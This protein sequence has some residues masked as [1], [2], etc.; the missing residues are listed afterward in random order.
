MVVIVKDLFSKKEKTYNLNK[1]VD[2]KVLLELYPGSLNSV[3]G[4]MTVNEAA[5]QIAKYIDSSSRVIS[6]TAD[7]INKA[8]PEAEHQK[9]SAELKLDSIFNFDTSFNEWKH[10]RTNNLKEPT[11]DS[12]FSPDPGRI[13]EKSL[14]KERPKTTIEKIKEKVKEANNENR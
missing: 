12:T 1:P 10:K 2:F 5:Q 3:L 9:Q 14:D 4:S 11:R 7:G 8:E 6:Y 13:R